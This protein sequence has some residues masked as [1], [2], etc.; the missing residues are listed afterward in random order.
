[1]VRVSAKAFPPT[2]NR[3]LWLA[4]ILGSGCW[5]TWKS[6][7][8]RYKGVKN[9]SLVRPGAHYSLEVCANGNERVASHCGSYLNLQKQTSFSTESDTGN[10]EFFGTKFKPSNK[11]D[12]QPLG[13]T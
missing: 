2:V 5:P 11:R 1:M 12:R 10:E 9:P 7:G 6:I 13:I 3:R 4:S 8:A